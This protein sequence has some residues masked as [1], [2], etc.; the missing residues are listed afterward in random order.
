[1]GAERPSVEI[2]DRYRE[3]ERPP[4]ACPVC[5]GSNPPDAVFCGNVD[6]HKALGEFRYVQE[7]L[8]AEARWHES[9]AQR[10]TDFIAKPQFLAVH[11]IWFTAW[12]ALNSGVVAALMHHFDTFP[13]PL[14]GIILAAEAIF[15]S[16]FILIT[17]NRQNVYA[18]KRAELDYVVGVQSY[19]EIRH[20]L[21]LMRLNLDRLERMQAELRSS[22]GGT[23]GRSE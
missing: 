20:L 7:E 9:L 8:R 17:Q 23:A 18:S 13:F 16:C 22:G 4:I 21:E 15:M 2:S 10:V 5:G 6:C 12:V 14:L 1:M 19:R 3:R 11:A